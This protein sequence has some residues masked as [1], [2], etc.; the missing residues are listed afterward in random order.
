MKAL[1]IFTSIIFAN[2]NTSNDYTIYQNFD[3]NQTAN[4]KWLISR[5]FKQSLYFCLASCN[6]LRQC[7]SLIFDNSNL[8]F[9]CFLYTKYFS[10]FD[11]IPSTDVVV[12]TKYGML[13][14][15]FNVV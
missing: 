10:T 15:L 4:E 14:F 13:T 2:A 8:N 1:I 11:L 5:S 9:N 3:V 6:S 12:H 7:L